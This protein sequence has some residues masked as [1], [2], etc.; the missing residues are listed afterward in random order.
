MSFSQL[1]ADGN[2][3]VSQAE[4]QAR[5]AKR[6]GDSDSNADGILTREELLAAGQKRSERRVERM[7]KRFDANGD[8]ALSKDE[9]PMHGA[10]MFA[11]ADADNSGGLSEEEFAALRKHGKRP[12][13]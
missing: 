6:F 8:G 3:E 12:K 9:L 5:A 13:N 1:D 4:L 11:R 2:G 7:L 10:D